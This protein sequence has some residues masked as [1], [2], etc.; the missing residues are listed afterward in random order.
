MKKIENKTKKKW[1]KINLLIAIAIII[2]LIAI[3]H[4]TISLVLLPSQVL[5]PSE[6]TK[7]ITGKASLAP[8]AIKDNFTN[9]QSP[10]RLIIAAEWLIVIIIILVILIKGALKSNKEM[11]KGKDIKEVK[12]IIKHTKSNPETDLD[13]LHRVLK[14]KKVLRLS[15]V[16]KLFK[17]NKNVTIEWF[18]ILEEANLA[19]IR[20]PTVGEP[21]IVLIEKEVKNEEKPHEK[22]RKKKDKNKEKHKER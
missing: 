4:T 2:F 10:S 5:D 3:I 15:V 11:H 19:E 18:K 17:V 8:N 14:E 16:A 7:G 9:I 22:E 6:G 13:V 20:Y 1:W 12:I 21:K